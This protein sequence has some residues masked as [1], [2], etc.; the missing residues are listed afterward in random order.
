MITPDDT[1]GNRARAIYFLRKSI[2]FID[3]KQLR[4]RI[5]RPG[6]GDMMSLRVTIT[7]AA[8]SVSIREESFIH[9]TRR[10]TA[11]QFNLNAMEE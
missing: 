11:V 5:P 4:R 9:L 6:H 2:C 8:G 3:V 10:P 7:N 1:G